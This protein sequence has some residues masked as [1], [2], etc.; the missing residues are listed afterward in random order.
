MKL[1][2]RTKIEIGFSFQSDISEIL[3]LQLLVDE[4]FE[5]I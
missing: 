2:V 5:Q 3:Q 4:L 1:S